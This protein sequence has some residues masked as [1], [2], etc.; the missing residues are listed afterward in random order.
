MCKFFFSFSMIAFVGGITTAPSP[1][2]VVQDC[3]RRPRT[4][5][6]DWTRQTPKLR[7]VK[8]PLLH[9]VTADQAPSAGMSDTWLLR[10]AWLR[11][12]I[13]STK[14][15]SDSVPSPIGFLLVARAAPRRLPRCVKYK[16]AWFFPNLLLGPKQKLSGVFY[17]HDVAHTCNVRPSS[18]SVVTL[19]SSV[20]INA[21]KD[22]F[23][24]AQFVLTWKCLR[25][26]CSIF[27]HEFQ[28]RIVE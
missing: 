20:T 4:K 27:V 9:R 21:S 14:A 26:R 25:S 3:A 6:K 11:I 1:A 8:G 16:F 12:S 19:I 23:I 15:W 28:I 13:T 24:F 22:C 10:R 5:T 18:L 2:S 7:P 17:V